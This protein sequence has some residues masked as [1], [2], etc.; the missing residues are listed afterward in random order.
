MD[1]KTP[2]QKSKDWYKK[3]KAKV[4]ARIKAKASSSKAKERKRQY[5]KE[6]R[7]KNR[8]KIDARLNKWY[9]ENKN[10]QV[11][12][13]RVWKQSNPLRAQYLRYKERAEKKK[14]GF[15]LDY[16]NF[17]EYVKQPCVYCGFNEGIVGLDR[18]DSDK[19][20]T[21]DNVVPCC[22]VCN[23]MKLDHKVENWFSYMHQVLEYQGYE[24]TRKTKRGSSK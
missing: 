15:D 4:L 5:D 24:I 8:D 18:I 14:I 13:A 22:K 23:Y 20:Y 7:Q 11:K 10:T 6:Y 12:K 19:G 1:N 3:N 9:Q 2:N 16:E 21:T 17:T